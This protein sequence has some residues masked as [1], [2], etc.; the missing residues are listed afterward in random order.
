MLRTN[1]TTCRMALAL[2]AVCSPHSIGV[3]GFT[4]FGLSNAPRAFSSSISLKESNRLQDYATLRNK[5]FALRHG[6]SK[7]NVAKIIA[8]DP[9]VACTQYGLSP[10]G[11]EQAQAAGSHVVSYY[12]AKHGEGSPLFGGV[13]LLTSDLLR[14]KETAE[15]VAAAIRTHNSS[16]SPIQIPLY[17]NQVI[18]ETRLRE[19]YFGDWD[20]T[21]DSNYHEV[22]KDDAIDPTHTLSGVESVNSVMNRAT[23]CVLDWDA[24]LEDYMIVCVAHGDVLQ[25][26]QTGFSKL[27][28]SKHRTLEHLETASL[29][30]L[31]LRT[32]N[33]D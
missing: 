23:D 25:I 31:E 12:E 2:A 18:I 17:E 3:Y 6:Q 11:H 9:E 27:D 15:A 5:Y 13:C 20:L 26:L 19:R 14:A 22:W 28:G 10:L 29:R 8:S 30:K 24:R 32:S 33:C 7:A 4:S 21:S 1:D 16:G